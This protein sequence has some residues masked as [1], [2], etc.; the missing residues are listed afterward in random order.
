MLS[1]RIRL[2]PW[3]F[4]FSTISVVLGHY[5]VFTSLGRYLLFQESQITMIIS[6]ASFI[7]I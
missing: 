6:G 7:L 1:L 5:N 3:G 4:Y 2:T